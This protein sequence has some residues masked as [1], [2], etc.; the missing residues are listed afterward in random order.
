MSSTSA[1]TWRDRQIQKGFCYSCGS[2]RPA[3]KK[4]R[5]WV[6]IRK[7]NARYARRTDS[8]R[9][10]Q[11]ARIRVIAQK[12]KDEVYAAYGGYCC[13]CCGET[14]TEF[15]TIDHIEGNGKKHREEVGSGG[16]GFVLYRWLKRHKFPKG[17]RILCM[18]CNF[19][20]GHFGHCPHKK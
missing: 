18:N 12:T 9:L 7:A 13:A 4:K 3:G 1:Q 2:R 17:F 5:C 19:A 15:L 16:R 20:L 11:N 8:E 10:T 6:C 14:N